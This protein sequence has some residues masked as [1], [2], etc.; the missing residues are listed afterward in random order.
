MS[1][2]AEEL[3]YKEIIDPLYADN[4]AWDARQM[5]AQWNF[6]SYPV[7]HR[8]ARQYMN[9]MDIH[10]IYQMNLPKRMQQA[11]VCSY[12]LS[13]ATIDWDSRCIVGWE[14]DD[15]LLIPEWPLPLLKRHSK[16][17]SPGF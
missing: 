6:H 2:S 11:K 12:L 14:V 1:V 8:K 15:N 13:N 7:G 9:E 10:P 4:L 3:A 5:S 16:P 17:Q